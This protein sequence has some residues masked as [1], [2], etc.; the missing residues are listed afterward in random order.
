ML[1]SSIAFTCTFHMIVSRIAIKLTKLQAYTFIY[2]SLALIQRSL[3]ACMHTGIRIY[4]KFSVP[5]AFPG[6]AFIAFLGNR[7]VFRI[8]MRFPY[9]ACIYTDKMYTCDYFYMFLVKLL[10][11]LF[12]RVDKTSDTCL[13]SAVGPIYSLQCIHIVLPALI[14]PCTRI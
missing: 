13:E 9:I 10:S 11:F 4:D 1:P 5:A 12:V 6:A 7:A 3:A 2:I 8:Y 14:T